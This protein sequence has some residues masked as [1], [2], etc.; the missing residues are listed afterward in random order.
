MS[1]SEDLDKF[2]S[3]TA[4]IPVG[5][6]EGAKQSFSVGP[7]DRSWTTISPGINF[8]SLV[9]HRWASLVQLGTSQSISATGEC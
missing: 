7:R 5:H 1:I 4:I 6:G 8:H 3:S 2:H 9:I